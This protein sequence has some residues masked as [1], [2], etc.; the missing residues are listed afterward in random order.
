MLT[1]GSGIE[2]RQECNLV[3]IRTRD[4]KISK[5]REI[6]I[7]LEYSWDI[8]IESEGLDYEYLLRDILDVA[9][10]VIKYETK[11]FKTNM[12]SVT[13]NDIFSFVQEKV[14]LGFIGEQHFV[15]PKEGFLIF[16]SV[17]QFIKG[18]VKNYKT[19]VKGEK[20]KFD[21]WHYNVDAIEGLMDD[22]TVS[23]PIKS[24]EIISVIMSDY[25]NHEDLTSREYIKNLCTDFKSELTNVQCEVMEIMIDNPYITN[26]SI[27]LQLNKTEGSIRKTKD[28]IQRKGIEFYKKVRI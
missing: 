15:K 26:L 23:K 8:W 17:R 21:Y 1:K 22:R 19:K 4:F 13:S 2:T 11:W 9:E 10:N 3:L 5:L 28:I 20:V 27:G 16:E 7:S 14:W 25:T 12:W 18:L 24:K 6:A